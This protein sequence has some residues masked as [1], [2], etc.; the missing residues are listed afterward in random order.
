VSLTQC[1]KPT[2]S[3]R[4]LAW[5]CG[6]GTGLAYGVCNVPQVFEA[7]PLGQ[8]WVAVGACVIGLLCSLLLRGEQETVP[9]SEAVSKSAV[10]TWILIFLALVWLDSA[11]FYALQHNPTM[12]SLTWRGEGT[13]WA[14]GFV[15]L[16]AAVAAGTLFARGWFAGLLGLAVGLLVIACAT[17]QLVPASINSTHWL[18]VVGVSLYSAGLVYFP[19]QVGRVG[20]TATLYSV[21]GWGGSAIGIAI[22]Q[23]HEIIPWWAIALAAAVAGGAFI[24]RRISAQRAGCRPRGAIWLLIALVLAGAGTEQALAAATTETEPVDPEIALGREVYIGEGCMYC[25]SQYVRPRRAEDVLAW[26]PAADLSTR[27]K[28]KPPLFGNRRL[29]PDLSNVGL[30]RTPEWNRLHL[31][32]PRAISGGSKMPSY[33]HLFNRD[34][35]RGPALVAYLASLGDNRFAERAE[36]VRAWSPQPTLA[37]SPTLEKGRH[38]FS[39][40]CVG[41]HGE[42]ALGNGALATQLSVRPANLVEPWKRVQTKDEFN[43]L[44]RVIK[45]GIVG[46]PMAG[47]EYLSDEEIVSIATYVQSLR[48]RVPLRENPSR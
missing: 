24:F 29:G 21:A 3:A 39:R 38:I 22:A 44:C 36:V 35:A 5:V 20:V 4:H 46:T 12:K 31:I 2:V 28:E 18:Y 9:R 30:R 43:S 11:A 19:A 6:A 1:L 32:A 33:A 14:N 47:R 48:Q 23:R 40:L 37:D 15:H 42:L 17:F 16:A 25:H 7:S 26:G 13:L 27:L 8:A 10:T 41:C 45:F 34:D